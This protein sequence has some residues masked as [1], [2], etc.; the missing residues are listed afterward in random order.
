MDGSDG[1]LD[2]GASVE[3]RTRYHGGW[4]GGFR[5]TEATDGGCRLARSDG[6]RLPVMFDWRDVRSAER[7]LPGFE[8]WGKIGA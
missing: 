5:I 7:R 1:R 8:D 3:V 4:V 2:A 6:S